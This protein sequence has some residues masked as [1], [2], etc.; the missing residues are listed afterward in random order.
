MSRIEKSYNLRNEC[1]SQ[2]RVFT[3]SFLINLYEYIENNEDRE[4]YLDILITEFRGEIP[5][6]FLEGKFQKNF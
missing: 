3:D 5:Q 6:K 2:E 1:L 4:K